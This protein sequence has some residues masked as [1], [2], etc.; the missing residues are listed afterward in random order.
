MTGALWSPAIQEAADEHYKEVCDGIMAKDGD[1]IHK[2][3][4][5]YVAGVHAKEAWTVS[6]GGLAGIGLTKK[7]SALSVQADLRSFARMADQGSRGA[8]EICQAITASHLHS[9]IA[10][11]DDVREVAFLLCGG[12]LKEPRTSGHIAKRQKTTRRDRIIFEM[13]FFLTEEHGLKPS[14]NEASGHEGSASDYICRCMKIDY[15]DISYE[16]IA[17]VW[18]KDPKQSKRNWARLTMKERDAHWRRVVEAKEVAKRPRNALADAALPL[19][20]H[21]ADKTKPEA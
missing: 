7:A 18:H 5:E 16:K 21:A 1:P 6:S 17:T 12:F 3:H 9:N 10:L 19:V 15:P 20:T 2:E 14:R 8:F 4:M 13:M 11:P